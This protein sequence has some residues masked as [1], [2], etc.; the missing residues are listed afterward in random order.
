MNI[1]KL[2]HEEL[3]VRFK[4][5][6]ITYSKQCPREDSSVIDKILLR[7]FIL[8]KADL[9]LGFRCSRIVN[10]TIDVFYGESPLIAM[11]RTFVM[12]VEDEDF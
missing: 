2:S 8:E 12:I 4:N 5:A 6:L 10:D 3:E 9:G 1:Q 11:K 7:G